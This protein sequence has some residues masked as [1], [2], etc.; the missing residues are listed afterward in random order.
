L[1]PGDVTPGDVVALM[2]NPTYAI[3]LDEQLCVPHEPILDEDTWVA[4]NVRA[5]EEIGAEAWLRNLLSVLKGNWVAGPDA[6][7]ELSD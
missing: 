3:E 5:I 4:A 6:Q 2:C 7:D 1:T